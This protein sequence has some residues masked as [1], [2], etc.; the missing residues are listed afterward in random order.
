MT[1]T[2]TTFRPAGSN[3]KRSRSVAAATHFTQSVA[4]AVTVVVVLVRVLVRV[5]AVA[6]R[7]LYFAAFKLSTV[8]AMVL[9]AFRLRSQT[10]AMIKP[11]LLAMQCA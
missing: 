7:E 1:L 4:V 11:G 9:A 2:A 8:A 3:T 10:P 5:L 6:K